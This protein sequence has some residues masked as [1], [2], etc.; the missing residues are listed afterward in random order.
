MKLV[1][2]GVLL[3]VALVVWLSSA[4]LGAQEARQPI[5]FNAVSMRTELKKTLAGY[6]ALRWQ[7]Q[8]PIF[9][10]IDDRCFV[11]L[12]QALDPS[13]AVEKGGLA[14]CFEAA[15]VQRK[16]ET[17]PPSSAEAH[18][19]AEM[20]KYLHHFA[21]PD[22]LAL[23]AL[24]ADLAVAFDP[25]EPLARSEAGSLPAPDWDSAFAEVG[26]VS[27]FV[28]RSKSR[29]PE[30]SK[31]VAAKIGPVDLDEKTRQLACK[32][33]IEWHLQG[34]FHQKVPVKNLKALATILDSEYLATRGDV[35]QITAPAKYQQLK[36]EQLRAAG[37]FRG[38]AVRIEKDSPPESKWLGRLF[39]NLAFDLDGT[40]KVKIKGGSVRQSDWS[41]YLEAIS[42]SRTDEAPAKQITGLVVYRGKAHARIGSAMIPKGGTIPLRICQVP[43]SAAGAE[44]AIPSSCG[45]DFV[46][47][48]HI[49]FNYVKSIR[50]ILSGTKFS[51]QMRDSPV[52]GGSAGCALALLFLSHADGFKIDG[53]V[54]VT[55]AILPDGSPKPVGGVYSKALAAANSIL[56]IPSKNQS[57]ISDFVFLSKNKERCDLWGR[58]VFTYTSLD[59]LVAIARVDRP[60]SLRSAIDLF[61]ETSESHDS[62]TADEKIKNL[63]RVLELAPN[64]LSARVLLDTL[65]MNPAPLL[66]LSTSLYFMEGYIY[67]FLGSRSSRSKTLA[68]TRN[69]VVNFRKIAHPTVSPWAATL[70]SAID[71]I[72]A[73]D[74]SDASRENSYLKLKT[75]MVTIDRMVNDQELLFLISTR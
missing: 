30:I 63:R 75:L 1:S 23:A 45:P 27:S 25:N 70:A 5:D 7:S 51:L 43:E 4:R 22:D 35:F 19:L 40:S 24:L 59:Q 71:E 61:R 72:T 53:G 54:S 60:E 10:P 57:E 62:L 31:G 21:T 18:Y 69:D 48:V 39:V 26:E 44:L 55:G 29:E 2:A 66:S 38:L 13:R 15:P 28:V 16:I 9:K 50:P 49:A 67:D 8:S 74:A 11:R 32:Y 52:D 58:Q 6:L 64:H 34:V 3:S 65:T 20:A 73:R 17:A 41:S 68:K 42:S 37:Y 36:A 12:V 33:I 46:K 47:S 14:W 56:A